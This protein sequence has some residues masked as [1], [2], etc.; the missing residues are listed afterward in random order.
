M[1]GNFEIIKEGKLWKVFLDG[2]FFIQYSS[3]ITKDEVEKRLK[4]ILLERKT[5]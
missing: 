4:V 2:E 3:S 5:S 1:L